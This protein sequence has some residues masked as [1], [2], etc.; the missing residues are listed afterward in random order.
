MLYSPVVTD[1]DY[2]LAI[3][4][5]RISPI[6][7]RNLPAILGERTHSS[8]EAPLFLKLHTDD[9]PYGKIL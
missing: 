3:G 4:R 1:C 7:W 2:Q 6:W 5:P 9:V 8:I